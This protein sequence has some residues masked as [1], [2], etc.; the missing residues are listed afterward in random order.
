MNDVRQGTPG[1]TRTAERNT[2]MR[3]M[4]VASFYSAYL[5][6]FRQ[7][8]PEAAG[9][10]YPAML[11]R[12]LADGFGAAYILTPSLAERGH[13]TAFAVANWIMGQAAWAAESGHPPCTTEAEA[14][15]ICARQIEA[16]RPDVL[17]VLDTIGLD[18]GFVRALNW[19]PRL[20]VGWRQATIPPGTD[21][22]GYDLMLSGDPGCLDEARR[23]GVPLTA[24]FRP[25]FPDFIAQAVRA[26]P[27]RHDLVFSGQVLGEHRTR[28]ALLEHLAKALQKR[29][30]AADAVFHLAV[31]PGEALP[32]DL[33]AFDRGP[34]WG[35]DMYSRLRSGRMGLNIHIDVT[36]RAMN[37]RVLEITG[38]GSMLLTEAD[39][40]LE[41]LFQP[42]REAETFADAAEMLD[43]IAFYAAHPALAE[44]I[45]AAGQARC[46][47][48]HSMARRA[49]RFEALIREAGV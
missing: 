46:L 21:W 35:R 1:T 42:S 7:R 28:T 27:R 32:P 22:T 43:K 40:R 29:E 30:V 18:G 9:L 31:P 17:Y 48:D 41:E 33:A 49:E 13:E 20:T 11:D 47:R 4:Q 23:L 14:R 2:P 8:V 12:L 3:I 5:R 44:T 34:V 26:E 25:G 6:A 10:S 37:M 45:A 38:V 36:G 39:P 15:A 24:S 16:F 19:K